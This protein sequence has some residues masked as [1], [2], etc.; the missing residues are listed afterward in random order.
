MKA[1][2]IALLSTLLFSACKKNNPSSDSNGN[3]SIVNT[4]TSLIP[5]FFKSGNSSTPTFTTISKSTDQLDHPCDLDF[6]PQNPGQLWVTT[7]GQSGAT[8]RNIIRPG[9]VV[10]YTNPGQSSQSSQSIPEMMKQHFIGNP[11]AISFAREQVNAPIGAPLNPA[12]TDPTIPSRAQELT[13]VFAMSNDNDICPEGLGPT[14]WTADLSIYDPMA[15]NHL[16]ML[17]NS[18][19]SLGIEADSEY[20]FWTYSG[21]DGCVV[22]FNFLNPHVPGGSYHAGGEINKYPEVQLTKFNR[23]GNVPAHLVKDKAT[24]WLYIV[25][26]VGKQILRMNTQTGTRSANT[27][28]GQNDPFP[29]PATQYT[30]TTGVTWEVFN[31]QN[32]QKP[33]GIE[34]VGNILYV[35]D[36]A[37]G[38]IIAYNK[39]TKKELARVNTG[40]PGIMGIKADNNG[41]LWYVN[42]TTNEVVR[43]DPQ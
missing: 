35:T 19:Y 23:P 25:D 6:N 17:H 28:G 30:K 38:E 29:N 42:G 5:G 2:Y 4:A 24:G 39:N 13:T 43:V 3:G 26:G 33:C 40:K 7:M 27:D 14:L 1:L 8:V 36:N 34:L 37:T 22:R 31:N 41:Q 20:A 32:L 10:I 12:P 11:T 9:D 18:P 15:N 21:F 16:D